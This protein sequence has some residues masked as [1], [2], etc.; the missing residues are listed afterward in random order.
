MAAEGTMV[1]PLFEE[2]QVSPSVSAEEA[3]EFFERHGF[4]YQT[5]SKIGRLVTTLD[6]DGAADGPGGL[7]FFKEA[8]LASPRVR[9]IL[10]SYDEHPS[11]WYSLGC[12][13]GHYFASTIDPHQDHRL[14]IYVW[15]P[16]TRL[17]FCDGSHI[18]QLKGVRA[19]NGMAEVPLSFLKKRRV[20][21]LQV[22]MEEGGIA[23]V[24]PRLAFQSTAGFSMA[25][26]VQKSPHK[27]DINTRQPLGG[28]DS[29]AD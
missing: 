8:L 24:H 21:I 1:D 29:K 10:E 13:P 17:E 4:F 18:G 20:S 5:D 28:Q 25:Y 12:D 26:A 11:L 6:N 22:K 16:G 7:A 27:T 15:S 19:S 3:P 14:V 9:K 23:L 2:S